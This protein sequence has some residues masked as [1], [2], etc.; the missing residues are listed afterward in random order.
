MGMF[1]YECAVCG[2]GDR[3]CGAGH[4]DGCL[5]GQFCWED[6]C[7]I[8]I[9]DTY[10]DETRSEPAWKNL[11][12]TVRSGVYDGYGRVEL[13]DSVCPEDW[14]FVPEEFEDFIEGWDLGPNVILVKIWCASC[15]REELADEIAYN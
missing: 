6:A 1:S 9:V 5:G 8:Q 7:M 10:N 4:E 14:V 13:N 11:R 2:G 15:F 12:G 3:R